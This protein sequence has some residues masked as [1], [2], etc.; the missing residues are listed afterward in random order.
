MTRLRVRP[1]YTRIISALIA[2]GAALLIVWLG[3]PL[4]APA[5]LLLSL[6]ALQEYAVL[7]NLRGVPIRRRSLWVATLLTLPASLPVTYT[8]LFDMQPLFAGV[9]WREALL[10][11]FALYLIGLEVIHPNDRS[12]ESVIYTL[13][14]YLYIPWLL[15]Y[16]ITLRYTPDGVLGLW[17]L[18]IPIL[19][20]IA[21]DAGAYIFGKLFGRRKLAPQVSPNKTLEG[22]FGGLASAI[23]IVSLVTFVLEL[24]LGLRVDIYD[25]LLFSVLVA[26]AAQL[27]DLFESLIKRWAGVKDAGFFLPGHGGALDRI[28]S[29]L[30]AVPVT[31]Y[32]V[33]LV[34]L[35]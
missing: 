20:I 29:M 33:V 32:F 12:V 18:M 7:M 10:G 25:T 30:F 4:L 6:V 23:V 31:Y 17:Y 35:R 1:P 15:G 19:A 24:V 27:G 26:S 13:F 22:A 34:V 8:G 9:S 2:L 11:L 16:A 3:I 21:S 28:D 5:Y 14:G